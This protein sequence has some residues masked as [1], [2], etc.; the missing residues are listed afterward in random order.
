M[1]K[2]GKKIVLLAAI[3]VVVV[4]AVVILAI[5]F[6][7][8]HRVIKV[9]SFDGE[10]SLE[11]D[12]DE[13]DMVEG[14]NLKSKDTIT[15]GEDGLVELLVDSDKHIL[16]RENTCFE[17]ISSGNEKAGKLK[18][19]L[20]Y[21][22]SLIE[23]ENKLNDDSTVEVKT[24][25]AS[26]SVRGTTF[27]VSYSKED[28]VTI[29]EVTDG[30]VEVSNGEETENVSE[31]ESA[32]V[33]QDSIVV[34]EIIDAD[35]GEGDDIIGGNDT[36]AD[37]S[38]EVD[39][40]E[41]G[42]GLPEGMLQYE[43]EPVFQ[44]GHPDNGRIS[45]IYVK[46]LTGWDYEITGY[47][48]TP[49]DEMV[50]DG[51][52][53]RY[54]I[55]TEEE[56]NDNFDWLEEEDFLKSL[57]YRKND[58]GDTIIT[59]ISGYENEDGSLNATY[60]YYKKIKDGWYLSLIVFSFDDPRAV[61]QMDITDFLPLTNDC[62][63]IIG[64]SEA[65]KPVEEV[66]LPETPIF[67]LE[68]VEPERLISAEEVPALFRGEVSFE[69]LEYAT[70]I[71]DYTRMKQNHRPIQN[72][73]S[74]MC[75]EPEIEGIYSPIPGTEYSYEVKNLNRIFSVLTLDGVHE[76][77]LPEGGIY[78]W[79]DDI[80]TL[81]PATE[82]QEDKIFTRI[83]RIYYGEENEICVDFNFRQNYNAEGTSYREG[84]TCMFFGL[85][86]ETGKYRMS[87]S[88][89]YNSREINAE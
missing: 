85:D 15:T 37:G 3:G 49:I 87:Y 77:F 1:K 36:D 11:R 19:K 83:I 72:A 23:I 18:I 86:E 80:L 27:E 63:Y 30:V 28:D 5:V 12:S 82:P 76:E 39:D 25:N 71:G 58:D 48:D 81:T 43:E 40:S 55:H 45:G 38:D 66:V 62:Y 8:G 53:I 16:A 14:M 7:G 60:R 57:D 46:Q 47:E 79:P 42:S 52:R 74:I 88:M 31:G 61:S 56:V 64:E 2:K 75:Y 69:E 65:M 89:E 68:Y 34:E 4:A 24:P 32:V 73:L 44:I 20:E 26:L 6:S 29:V 21:G 59:A 78:T 54:W 41:A 35:D 10:V 70:K 22:T 9:E 51:V 33:A 13:K 50:R 67:P 84:T 17:I